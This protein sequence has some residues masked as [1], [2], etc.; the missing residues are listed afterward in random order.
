MDDL[1]SEGDS[2]RYS[3]GMIMEYMVV[4]VNDIKMVPLIQA[5]QI[6]R[7]RDALL[8]ANKNLRTMLELYMRGCRKNVDNGTE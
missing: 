5:E 8:I 2:G 1:S 7:E 6:R 3:K 4:V